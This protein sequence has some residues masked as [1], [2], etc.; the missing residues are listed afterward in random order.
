M[1]RTL[2]YEPEHSLNSATRQID[3]LTPLDLF[4][5]D[6]MLWVQSNSVRSMRCEFVATPEQIATVSVSVRHGFMAIRKWRSDEYPLFF[7]QVDEYN[8]EQL[9][10]ALEEMYSSLEF[11]N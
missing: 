2:R 10:E 5:E 11:T 3:T 7:R 9:Q 6:V 8:P 1:S 4:M